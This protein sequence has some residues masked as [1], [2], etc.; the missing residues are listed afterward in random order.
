MSLAACATALV[1]LAQPNSALEAAQKAV[2]E[3]R[4]P[5][6]RPLLARARLS[7]S[8]DRPT[9][10][11]ILWLQGLVSASL[12]QADSARSAFRTL[13]SIE[14]EYT[15][16]KEQPPKVMT[17]F[18]EARGWVATKGHLELVAL[19]PARENGRVKRIGLK[20]A[21]DPM[22]LAM[23]VR[24]HVLG[25]GGSHS[26]F[27]KLEAWRNVDAPEVSWWAELIGEREAVLEVL[28]SADKP[29]VDKGVEVQD[30]PTTT[31]TIE[32]PPAVIREPTERPQLRTYAKAGFWVGGA[33]FV[34][35]VAFMSV[36]GVLTAKLKGVT[37]DASQAVTSL[38]QVEAYALN[39]QER[40]FAALGNTLLVLGCLV[41]ATGI[42]LYLLGGS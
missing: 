16:S 41:L 23:S 42:I 15:P 1:L 32:P 24:I 4:Y 34:G 10:L 5:D 19:P 38:T 3:L 35:G 31:P 40:T 7:P 6:A 8:L 20:V 22:G 17:P 11:E 36:A 13:L 33:A 25:E 27:L 14:P 28:G 37:R 29:I 21:A 2:A 12:G 9:L 26:E 39:S 30:V 18:Y